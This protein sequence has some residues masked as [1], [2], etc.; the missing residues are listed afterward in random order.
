M[1]PDK[2]EAAWGDNSTLPAHAARVRGR[3][4]CAP[5]ISLPQS[6]TG[7]RTRQPKTQ[8]CNSPPSWAASMIRPLSRL[9]R[10]EGELGPSSPVPICSDLFPP[11]KK[12]RHSSSKEALFLAFLLSCVLCSCLSGR[13][14]LSSFLHFFIVSSCVSCVLCS[15]LFHTV[16]LFS[17]T[18][19]LKVQHKCLA[20][21]ALSSC[22]RVLIVN[23][24]SSTSKHLLAVVMYPKKVAECTPL[25]FS[26]S[27][28]PRGTHS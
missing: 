2:R 28:H 16:S 11:K 20:T 22:V 6:S 14:T 8:N 25:L 24:G 4:R 10:W 9:Y 12:G 26:V 18:Q 21:S 7:C 5:K 19:L 13:H 1:P 15:C 17:T 3:E 23:S 27:E